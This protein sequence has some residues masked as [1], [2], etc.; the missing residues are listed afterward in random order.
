LKE[1]SKNFFDFYNDFN[2]E[3]TIFVLKEKQTLLCMKYV[4][5]LWKIK[6]HNDELYIVILIDKRF[7]LD[8]FFNYVAWLDFFN[9]KKNNF[10]F[11]DNNYILN[12]SYSNC[13]TLLDKLFLQYYIKNNI[14]FFKNY[15]KHELFKIK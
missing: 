1:E 14:R 6:L 10:L 11:L 12:K 4:Q 15:H 7:N 2:K 13:N 5:E 8:N 9:I 3:L